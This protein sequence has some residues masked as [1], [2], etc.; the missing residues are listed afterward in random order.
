LR[1]AIEIRLNSSMGWPVWLRYGLIGGVVAF[2]STL[3]IN[4]AI[5]LVQPVNLCR[6]GPGILIPLFLGSFIVFVL[7]AAGAGFA[8]ARS[9]APTEQASLSGIVVGAVSGCA[10]VILLLFSSSMTQRLQQLAAACPDGGGVTFFGSTPPPGFVVP[11]PPPEALAGPLGGPGM[12]AGLTGA[13]ISIGIGI[14]IAYGAA[15]L[16]A[17]IASATRSRSA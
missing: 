17:V 1:K 4:L 3:G 6:A 8:S 5:L 14:A 15:A 7:M 11:T 10:P 12:I 9:G 2:A 13:V 16:G